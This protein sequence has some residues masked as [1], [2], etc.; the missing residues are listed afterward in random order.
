MTQHQSPPPTPNHPQ[1]FSMV[2]P[3]T[4]P[5]LKAFRENQ[6]RS[7]VLWGWEAHVCVQQTCLDLLASGWQVFVVADGTSS[8]RRYDRECAL[9]LMRQ[10]GARITT[11]ESLLFELMRAKEHEHFKAI[12]GI[13][14]GYA[15]ALKSLAG[16]ERCDGES[17]RI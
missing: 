5:I 2:T 4:E 16:A 6:I 8:Q 9:R 15:D 3:D 12:Q 14:I 11:C 10:S 13:A 7:A 17:A 1:T